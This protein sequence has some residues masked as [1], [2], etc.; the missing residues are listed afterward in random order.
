MPLDENIF[1]IIHG[2]AG[3]SILADNLAV[4]AARYVPYLLVI[5]FF[6]L[7][8]DVRGARRK[9]FV[10][11]QAVI[12]ALVGR[13]IIVETIRFLYDRPRPFELFGFDPLIAQSPLEPAFPSGHAT[14]FFGLA[15]VVWQMNRTWGMWYVVAALLNGFTRIFVGV[16]WPL[17]IAMGAA[18]GML[19]AFVVMRIAGEHYPHLPEPVAP[20]DVPENL[21][22]SGESEV[23]T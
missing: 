21:A 8:A 23:L 16:H 4:L 15:F 20:S 1:N 3:K 10:L 7:L 11:A 12:I 13:G 2:F 6:V 17:D 9:I 22:E 19:T 14:F 5:G 18:I